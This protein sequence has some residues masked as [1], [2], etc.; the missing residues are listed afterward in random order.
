MVPGGMY[1]IRGVI[2]FFTKFREL[3]HAPSGIIVATKSEVTCHEDCERAHR[4]PQVD[5]R[6]SFEKV[7]AARQSCTRKGFVGE[8]SLDP[9]SK[10]QAAL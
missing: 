10:Q 9:P 3:G 1:T 8:R 5:C 6:R 7:K 4:R 2:L